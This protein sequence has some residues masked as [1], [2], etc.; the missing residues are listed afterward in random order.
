MQPGGHLPEPHSGRGHDR[1]G[2]GTSCPFSAPSLAASAVKVGSGRRPR[3]PPAPSSSASILFA[4]TGP[5]RP[6]GQ[7]HTHAHTRLCTHIK[8]LSPHSETQMHTLTQTCLPPHGRIP[9]RQRDTWNHTPSGAQKVTGRACAHTDTHAHMHMQRQTHRDTHVHTHTPRCMH[10]GVHPQDT[11]AHSHDTF[12]QGQAQ[13]CRRDVA[14]CSVR[15][16]RVSR[17]QGP[18]ARL[19]ISRGQG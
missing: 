14:P 10:Q 19:G 17:R 13:S 5:A 15:A 11:H 12:T 4:S 3:E 18:E 6:E 9:L 7:A 16:S 1:P 8:V 2:A